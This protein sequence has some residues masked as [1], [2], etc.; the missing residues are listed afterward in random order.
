[1]SPD[2]PVSPFEKQVSCMKTGEKGRKTSYSHGNNSFY[3][4]YFL[5]TFKK[6]CFCGEMYYTTE[7]K[8]INPM[9][10]LQKDYG[11]GQ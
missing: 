11:W 1:M 6:Q 3:P 8:N 7:N 5:F 4:F 2:M 10:Q 9:V